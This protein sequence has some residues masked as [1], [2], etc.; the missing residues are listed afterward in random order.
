MRNR[1][2]N[3]KVNEVL[4]NKAANY[5]ASTLEKLKES[6]ENINSNG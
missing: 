1:E 6:A 4:Y 2:L 5:K 3:D